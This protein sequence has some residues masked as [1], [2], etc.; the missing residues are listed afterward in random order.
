[1]VLSHIYA[2]THTHTHIY[3]YIYTINYDLKKKNCCSIYMTGWDFDIINWAM[4][5]MEPGALQFRRVIY[6]PTKKLSAKLSSS[7][8]VQ[9]KPNVK[10]PHRF[11]T[12]PKTPCRRFFPNNNAL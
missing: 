7:Y 2:H 5:Y 4:P 11:R 3:I 10:L 6:S 8:Q 9:T 12:C 1:M